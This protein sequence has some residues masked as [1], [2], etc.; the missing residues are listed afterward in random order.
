MKTKHMFVAGDRCLALWCAWWSGFA[1]MGA[2]YGPVTATWQ[3]GIGWFSFVFF[4]VVAVDVTRSLWR[5]VDRPYVNDQE[6]EER[7]TR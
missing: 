5:R 1:L 7:P 4:A 2:L 6:A 3:R